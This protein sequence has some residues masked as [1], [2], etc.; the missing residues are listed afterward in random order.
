[1]LA[2]GVWPAPLLDVM[3]PT[4]EQ[5]VQQMMV[6]QALSLARCKQLTWPDDRGPDAGARRSS[7]P[8]A[9]CVVLL[10]DAFLPASA[11][12]R[13]TFLLAMPRSLGPPG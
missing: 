9:A 8:L 12:Q 6:E 5:L 11:A 2:L 1:M 13:W 7:S 10:V 3:R 4:L